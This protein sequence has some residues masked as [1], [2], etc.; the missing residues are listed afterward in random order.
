MGTFRQGLIAVLFVATAMLSVGPATADDRETCDKA[1]GDVAIAACTRVINS[2]Q[3]NGQLL[4]EALHSR[5]EEYTG[6]GKFDL[7]LR[8]FDVS[9]RLRPNHAPTLD[10]RGRTYLFMKQFEKAIRDFDAALRFA[11][12]FYNSLYA[13]GWAKTQIGNFDGGKADIAAAKAMKSDVVEA[14]GKYYGITN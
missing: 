11:P 9:L 1:S 3:L 8:D 5:G 4:A 6:I 2:G 12:G 10:G 13:R 7:A 14:W